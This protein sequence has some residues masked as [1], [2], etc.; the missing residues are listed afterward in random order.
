MFSIKKVEWNRFM[1]D[2]TLCIKNLVAPGGINHHPKKRNQGNQNQTTVIKYISLF[3]KRE[4]L[5]VARDKML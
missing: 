3:E 4:R 2:L 5:H 1:I